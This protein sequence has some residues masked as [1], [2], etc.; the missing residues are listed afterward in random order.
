MVTAS[1]QSAENRKEIEYICGLVRKAGFEDVCFIRDVEHYQH[2]F[3]D[4]KELMI[5]AAQEIEDCDY[6]LIDMTDKPTGR[7]YEAGIAYA[8]GKKVVVIMKAGTAIKDTTKGIAD[9]IIEY[10]SIEDIVPQLKSYL[11]EN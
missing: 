6:L 10:E 5:K 7:A 2:I 1:F 9:I 11:D 4:P 8:F 3:D